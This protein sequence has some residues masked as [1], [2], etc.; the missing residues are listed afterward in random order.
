VGTNAE[1]A[2]WDGKRWWVASAAAG[3]A[4]EG[5][6]ISSGM[7]MQEG[8]VC[9]V[10]LVDDH[11][12]L[13]VNGGESPLGVCGSGLAALVATALVGGLID[14][15]GRIVSPDKV[16]T[17]LGRYLV[18][19]KDSWAIRYHRSATTELLLTQDDVSNFQLAKGAVSAGVQLL[20][21]RSG[22]QPD[23]VY[24]VVLTG[25]L[26]TTL[27]TE[28][29]KRVALL[30]EAMLDRTSF[31]KNGVLTGLQK[32]LLSTHGSQQLEDVL[33]KAQP[34]PL[35]GSPAFEKLFLSSLEF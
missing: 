9:G 12:Q 32:Y 13:E 31:I 27:P 34:F 15:S 23:D 5:G 7:T 16:E 25:A 1:I 11:L 10:S 28:V 30:P 3:P 4:F 21:E 24:E 6:N 18:K 33:Q 29:L 2:F 26:G 14:G 17:N 35:S 20:L 22:L 8:A 19:D